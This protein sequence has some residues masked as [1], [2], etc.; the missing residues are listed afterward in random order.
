MYKPFCFNLYRM[1][2]AAPARGKIKQ[3]EPVKLVRTVASAEIG[4]LPADDASR[5]EALIQL[6]RLEMEATRAYAPRIYP[7]WATADTIVRMVASRTAERAKAESSN[8]LWLPPA[9]VELFNRLAADPVSLA[10]RG[11]GVDVAKTRP[12]I[13][14]G[15][16][17]RVDNVAGS[18]AQR[19]YAD[20][21]LNPQAI[22]VKVCEFC[23]KLFLDRSKANRA[24][25]CSSQC[26]WR[27]WSREARK[28]AGH[29]R[30][31]GG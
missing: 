11:M 18:V 8:I 21:F 10:I 22:R 30:R 3:A 19:L 26:T 16:Q 28:S 17:L 15:P 23:H 24:L 20:F 2:K 7:I 4:F 5:L 25:R 29:G 1:R 14:S 27:R 6:V 31:N 12:V 13:I 9:A